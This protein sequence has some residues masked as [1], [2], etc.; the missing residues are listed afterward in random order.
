[1]NKWYALYTKPKAEKKAAEQ[2]ALKG[3]D[4]YLPLVRKRKQWSDRKV[5]VNEPLIRSYI[6]VNS[7]ESQLT[8]AIHTPGI[9]D[10]VRFENK[11]A[12]IPDKQIALLKRLIDSEE[13]IE[14]CNEK[15]LAG[16]EVEV[17]FGKLYGMKGTLVEHRG[18]HKVLVRFDVI[19]NII[20]VDIPVAN[21]RKTKRSTLQLQT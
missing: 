20:L 5:W 1:M 10:I 11:A 18:R 4:Y 21:L 16:E 3:I 12:V 7:K 8:T 14:V 17:V 15:F 6:F 9:L 19:E 13:Q 2:L